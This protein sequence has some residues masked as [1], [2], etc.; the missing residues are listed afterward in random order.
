MR[1]NCSASSLSLPALSL[2][3][4][5]QPFSAHAKTLAMNF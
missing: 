4:L 1:L 2:P 5:A 3:A